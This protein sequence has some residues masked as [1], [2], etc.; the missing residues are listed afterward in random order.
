MVHGQRTDSHS[1][2]CGRVRQDG[3]TR[4]VLQDHRT[5]VMT[6]SPAGQE[7]TGRILKRVLDVESYRLLA[8]LALPMAQQ[9]RTPPPPPSPL[10]YELLP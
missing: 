2:G 3:Y 5:A 9:A 4:I 1:G 7:K 8:L 6:A 10:Y